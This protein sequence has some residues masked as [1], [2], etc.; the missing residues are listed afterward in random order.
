MKVCGEGVGL[1]PDLR[2]R[3]GVGAGPDLRGAT[4]GVGL[5][6]DLR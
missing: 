2:V 5:K 3:R 6:P 1:K 4:Q